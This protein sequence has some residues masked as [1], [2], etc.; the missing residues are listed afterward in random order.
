LSV[1]NQV[2]GEGRAI[3]GLDEGIFLF[4]PLIKALLDVC[5]FQLFLA[6]RALV[7]N[8]IFFGPVLVAGDMV[9]V[10]M[11][12]RQL[13]ELFINDELVRTDRARRWVQLFFNFLHLLFE[14]F[15]AWVLLDRIH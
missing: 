12:A 14:N 7:R 10:L 6:S 4:M 3:I 1:S 11:K 2:F 8:N 9:H 15:Y 5:Q 13:D